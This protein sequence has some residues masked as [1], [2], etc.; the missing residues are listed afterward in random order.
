MTLDEM[1]KHPYMKGHH[2]VIDNAPNH[3]HGNIRKYIEYRGY[4]RMYLLTYSPKLN[5]IE[6][7]WAMVKSKVKRHR[8]LQEDILSKRITE[9]CKSVDKTHFKGFVSH[10][11]KGW[12]RNPKEIVYPVKTLWCFVECTKE[13]ITHLPSNHTLFLT[14]IEDDDFSKISSVKD[15]TIAQWITNSLTAAGIDPDKFTAHSIRAAASTY[16]VQQGASI[17]EVKIHANWSLNADTF[18]KYYLRPA[19]RRQQGQ[20]I[21]KRILKD[22]EKKPHPKSEWNSQICR[23]SLVKSTMGDILGWSALRKALVFTSNNNG[24]YRLVETVISVVRITFIQN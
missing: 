3:M 15:K 8:F 9:A 12:G 24:H 2:I 11:Y 23:F 20:M 7:F 1:D 4:K 21:S 17:Q 18:E 19:N 22:T 16:A 10:S 5:P 14:Y 13:R 6:Q